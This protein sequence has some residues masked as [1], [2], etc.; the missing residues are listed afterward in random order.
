M[1]S[2]RDVDGGLYRVPDEDRDEDRDEE[3]DRDPDRER[4]PINRTPPDYQTIIKV[5]AL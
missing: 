5:G 3:R 1:D 4:R 2:G